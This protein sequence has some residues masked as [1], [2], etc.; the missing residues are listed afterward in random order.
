ML[1]GG[2]STHSAGA[3]SVISLIDD[4]AVKYRVCILIFPYVD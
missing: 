2:A 1:F 3:G 4:I